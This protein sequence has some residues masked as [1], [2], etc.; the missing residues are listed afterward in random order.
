M[1]K[2]QT[3]F[4]LIELVIVIVILGILAAT[5]LPRFLDLS[6]EA[7]VASVKGL[8]GGVQAAASVARAA[9]IVDASCNTGAATAT[10]SIEGQNVAM[11]YGYPTAGATGIVAALDL[12]ATGATGDFTFAA[13]TWTLPGQTAG[14][15]QVAYAA[16]TSATNPATT[17]VETTC[18]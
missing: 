2:Q 7:K 8:G 3:G 12:P 11:A 15:C 10:A 13:G 9:C 5:A 17:T 6:Q 1:K 4:T 18:Q 14:Q 16:A